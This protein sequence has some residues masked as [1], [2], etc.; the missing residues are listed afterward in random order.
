MRGEDPP[1]NIL[2]LQIV[3]KAGPAIIHA[4]ISD[5]E[6]RGDTYRK[7][8]Q[9]RFINGGVTGS[10]KYELNFADKRSRKFLCVKANFSQL[11]QITW[12][13]SAQFT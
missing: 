11:S 12:V 3:S 7:E 1:K 4:H 6:C 9:F 13:T 10:N 2:I 8:C 5:Q